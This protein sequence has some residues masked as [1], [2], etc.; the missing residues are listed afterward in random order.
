[1]TGRPVTAWELRAAQDRVKAHPRD[2]AQR[3]V[4]VRDALRAGWTEREVAAA[5]GLTYG[6]VHQIKQGKR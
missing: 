2:R 1:M 3:D 6:R 4:L 5:M